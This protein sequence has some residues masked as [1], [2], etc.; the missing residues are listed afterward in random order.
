M[1][2]L[3]F[4][5]TWCNP[6]KTLAKLLEEIEM[7]CVVENFDIE[8]LPELA[9]KYRVRGVPTLVYLNSEDV[10]VKRL[11]GAQSKLKIEEWLN[12]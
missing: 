6:C 9:Q 1:R 11:V 7:P 10:E 5:A 2:I 8:E 3:K 12:E 4:G